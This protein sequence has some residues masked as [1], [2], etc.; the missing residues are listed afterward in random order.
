MVYGGRTIRNRAYSPET[1]FPQDRPHLVHRASGEAP[2]TDAT[3]GYEQPRA[4]APPKDT[5]LGAR[6]LAD[7]ARGGC[8]AWGELD[9]YA[10]PQSGGGPSLGGAIHLGLDVAGAV[11]G[12]GEPFDLAN[13][14]FY[15]A[16]GEQ[17]DAV[18]SCG[19]A[20]PFAGWAATGAK[21]AKRGAEA[22]KGETEIVQRA[23]SRAELDATLETGLVRGGREGTHYA[24]DAVNSGAL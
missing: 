13:C 1:V 24:N 3:G 23:M 19:A 12:L 8:A 6:C 16:E 14:G 20:I 5:S 7:A 9:D 15:A 10:S 21:T 2:L 11:P 22:A 4:V 17:G 18:L